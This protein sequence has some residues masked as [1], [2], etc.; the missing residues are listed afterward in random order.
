VGRSEAARHRLK[1]R[2]AAPHNR[3]ACAPRGARQCGAV[4]SRQHPHARHASSQKG[5]WG[6]GAAVCGAVAARMRLKRPPVCH[7]SET[8]TRCDPSARSR[9]DRTAF[10]ARVGAGGVSQ[11]YDE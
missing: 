3:C 10:E 2:L 7:A 9:C 6:C 1:L 5:L 11:C 8:E 4:A